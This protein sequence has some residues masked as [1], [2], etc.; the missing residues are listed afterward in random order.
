MASQKK[1][2]LSLLDRKENQ[3]K[4]EA[5]GPCNAAM[6]KQLRRQLK[7]IEAAKNRLKGATYGFCET[8]YKTIPWR[9]LCTHPEKRSC[10]RCLASA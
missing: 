6:K 5:K 3:I 7:E 10:D 1:T 2:I 4:E 9:E 8:C